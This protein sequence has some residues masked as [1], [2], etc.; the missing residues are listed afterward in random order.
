MAC[1]VSFGQPGRSA[2]RKSDAYSLAPVTLATPSMRPAPGAA[3]CQPCRPG[4][5]SRAVNP[6]SSAY[7]KRDRLSAMPLAVA[8]LTNSRREL[9]MLLTSCRTTVMSEAVRVGTAHAR[10]QLLKFRGTLDRQA[11]SLAASEKLYAVNSSTR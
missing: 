7:A 10:H 2:A 6:L 4:S 1:E 9:L 11:R 5:I 3:G 8:N